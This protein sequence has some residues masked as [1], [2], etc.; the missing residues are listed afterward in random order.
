M[1]YLR[2]CLL[3]FTMMSIG[4]YA[5]IPQAVKKDS[6]EQQ[7]MKLSIEHKES[8]KSKNKVTVTVTFKGNKYTKVNL[9]NNGKNETVK[10]VFKDGMVSMTFEIEKEHIEKSALNVGTSDPKYAAAM[11]GPGFLVYLKEYV[12]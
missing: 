7:E 11:C 6:A 12:A 9:M 1:N 3:L 2:I 10:T 8:T 5:G 4:L